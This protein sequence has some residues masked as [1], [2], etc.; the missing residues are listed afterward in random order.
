MELTQKQWRDFW[1]RVRKSDGDG[2]WEWTGFAIGDFGYGG[3]SL[4]GKNVY[5]HRLS[6]EIAH[7]HPPGKLCVLHHCDNPRC[8]RPGHLFLGT[9]VDNMKDKVA[10]GRQHRGERTA[11]T[12]L[13]VDK[14]RAILERYATG[15]ESVWGLS[16]EL[17]VNEGVVRSVVNGRTW[18]HV[19]GPRLSRAEILAI[20]KK[21]R[22]TGRL[23]AKKRA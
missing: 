21:N 7:G 12:L 5:A 2:C 19:P 13:S 23:L 3:F 15:L 18:A 16:Q 9:R 10:K 14:V 8:V 1:A 22:V 11:G 17:G 20:G 4:N 6:Y